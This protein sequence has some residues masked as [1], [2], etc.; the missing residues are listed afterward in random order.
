MM[1][2]LNP[3]NHR[4]LSEEEAAAKIKESGYNEI[5][6]AQKRSIFAIAFEVL[7][8]PMFLM[9]VGGGAIYTIL[10]DVHEALMLLGFVF[11]VMGITLYQ[12]RKV[13]RALEA[14][15]DLASPRALVIR[16]GELKRIPGRE[17]V[18]DDLLVL[19]EGD[20]VPADAVVLSCSNLSVDE[21]ALNGRICTGS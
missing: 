21:F 14:L 11:V 6:T 20:R 2:E 10:G 1:N 4:G 17:V 7:R 16:S 15:R 12:E 3:G 13:E 19:A 18:G 5:P 8:Q 9:L